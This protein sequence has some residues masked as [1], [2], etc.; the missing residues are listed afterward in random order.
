M[1]R[2]PRTFAAAIAFGFIAWIVGWLVFANSE[3]SSP[4]LEGS[5]SMAADSNLRLISE[6]NPYMR[7]ER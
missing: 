5:L 3:K 4:S 2:D 7:T 1:V 6:R